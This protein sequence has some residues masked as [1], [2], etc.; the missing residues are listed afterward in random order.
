[1]IRITVC[2]DDA[3][4]V[5]E[6]SLT[7]EKVLSEVNE[8]SKVYSFTNSCEMFESHV[9]FSLIFLDIEM[10]G[11]NGIETAQKIREVDSHVQIVYVTNYHD[12]MRNAYRVH[13]FDYIQKPIEYESIR[14]VICDYLKTIS[15][16]TNDVIEFT[17]EGLEK[18]LLNANE[19]ITIMCGYKRRTIVVITTEKEYIF[20]GTITDIYETLDEHEFF[21]PNRSCIINMSMVKSF[22]K[23]DNITMN[24][25]QDI[26]LS[27]G[28]TKVF[29]AKLAQK[30]HEKV[31]RRIL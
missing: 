3:E 18:I 13:A 6:L 25:G 11:L 7:I 30:M 12:Y 17:T 2:D 31:N 27:K 20:K 16:E 10:P 5:E 1:M 8:D 22:K 19:I 23:N 21:M 28:N 4:I 26:S 14:T 9:K 15:S 29:E 24:D